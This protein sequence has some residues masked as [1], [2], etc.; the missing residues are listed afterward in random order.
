MTR[1]EQTTAGGGRRTALTLCDDEIHR[2]E[3]DTKSTEAKKQPP[4]TR[5]PVRPTVET[6]APTRLASPQLRPISMQFGTTIAVR[7]SER[8][9]WSPA[10]RRSRSAVQ[11]KS[12]F[13]ESP[14]KHGN[15]RMASPLALSEI[16][17][18]KACL[19][20]LSEIR[21]LEMAPELKCL[22]WLACQVVLGRK[23]TRDDGITFSVGRVAVSSSLGDL[24][25][26]G[27]QAE[28]TRF[29]KDT[30][31]ELFEGACFSSL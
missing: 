14:R 1:V 23:T 27:R 12:R 13:A 24:G 5:G 2:R 20:S 22:K 19:K 4:R 31:A 9:R 3:I 26:A 21:E 28:R 25:L 17:D 30:R 7:A 29:L 10:T 11:W 15:V 18:R 6:T 16:R 8:L